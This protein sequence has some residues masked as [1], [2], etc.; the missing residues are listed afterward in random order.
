[1]YSTEGQKSHRVKNALG[2]GY[3]SSR[4]GRDKVTHLSNQLQIKAL[5]IEPIGVNYATIQEA[6][7][8]NTNKP[9]GKNTSF[10]ISRYFGCC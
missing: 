7:Q 3:V 4:D 6:L 10:I 5:G 8:S 1:M 2:I 9:S